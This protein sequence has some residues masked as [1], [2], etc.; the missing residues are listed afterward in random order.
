MASYSPYRGCD[1]LRSH[2]YSIEKID[3]FRRMAG[4]C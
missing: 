3:L 1:L 4:R 2:G